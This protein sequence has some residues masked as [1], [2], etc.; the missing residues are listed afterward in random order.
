M[1]AIPYLITKVM[2]YSRW[3]LVVFYGGLVAALLLF[4]LY[5]IKKIYK[6]SLTAGGMES[7]DLILSMLS[8]IDMTLIASLIVMVLISGYDSFVAKFSSVQGGE[9][10]EDL[11]HVSSGAIKLKISTAI[12]VISSIYILEMSMDFPKFNTNEILWALIMHGSLVA[13]GLA[14]AFIERM[15]GHH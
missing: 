15:S 14:L 11:T 12:I 9:K 5:Y 6:V 10:L 8:M 4:G 3:I 2:Y 1:S 13:T 7:S